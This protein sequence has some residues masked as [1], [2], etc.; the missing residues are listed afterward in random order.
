[1]HSENGENGPFEDY[2]ISLH[3]S[4]SACAHMQKLTPAVL[5]ATRASIMHLVLGTAPLTG[6]RDVCVGE[7]CDTSRL[8]QRDAHMRTW[9]KCSTSHPVQKCAHVYIIFRKLLLYPVNQTVNIDI[10]TQLWNY[11]FKFINL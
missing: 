4:A 7:W 11:K 2:M 10:L 9:P 1:M 5:G 3:R 6:S 8:V